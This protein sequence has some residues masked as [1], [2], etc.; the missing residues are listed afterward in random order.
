MTNIVAVTI[1][2]IKGIGLKIL[3]QSFKEKKIKNFIL[4]NNKKIIQKYIKRK[5]IKIKLNIIYNKDIKNK[6]DISKFKVYSYIS[7]H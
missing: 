5:N 6:F 7:D 4:F 2:D 1:G 3:I